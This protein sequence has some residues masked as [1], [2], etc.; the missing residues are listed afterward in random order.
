[1]DTFIRYVDS[2]FLVYTMCILV[3]I[4][5]SW[6]TVAPMRPWSQA[7]VRF[8]HDTTNWYLGFWRRIIPPVGPLDLSPV[9]AIIILVIVNQF[10][11]RILESL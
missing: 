2:F 7:L 10:V 8:F 4:L 1:M 3:R 5:M 9:V 11:V 6:V